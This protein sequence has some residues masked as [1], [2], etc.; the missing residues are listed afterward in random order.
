MKNLNAYLND[1]A[2]ID[3][4]HAVD[5]T[6]FGVAVVKVQGHNLGVDLLLSSNALNHLAMFVKATMY[7]G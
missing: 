3:S 1:N 2:G 6:N 5:L 7:K 4:L